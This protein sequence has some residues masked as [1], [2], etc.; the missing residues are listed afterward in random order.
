MFITI[1]LK[2]LSIFLIVAIGIAAS[3]F[4]LVPGD[5]LGTL[6]SFVLNIA[7]PCMVL[8]S[9]QRDEI[10][11]Y[12]TN[13]I[14]WS[15]A[16][17]AIV[18]L[19]VLLLSSL[20]I[21]PVKA[22]KE[23]D[24]GIYRLQLA[25]TNCGFMGY[26]LVTVILGKYALFLAIIMNIV[27]TTL[28]YSV[29]I[30]TLEHQRG[31]KIVIMKIIGQMLTL[32]FISSIAG[33]IIFATGYHF[34]AFINDSL[35][36]MAATLSPMAMFVVGVNLSRARLKDIFTLRNL[37]LCILSLVVV[38]ALTLAV[39]LILPVSK[40]VLTTHVFLMA[41]PSPAVV[42]ILCHRYRKNALL[43]SEGVAATTFLSLGT[44]SLW[45]FLLT[46]VFL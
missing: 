29:G 33:I 40:A 22:V 1:L 43:A 8:Q 45:A 31:E 7:V 38:P 10:K 9:M 18:T 12:M 34:P 30:F 17:F 42:T 41:M 4:K 24:K 25:F 16:A 26:P 2:I 3:K 19:L 13:D 5:C 14:I 35:E 39:D 37:V 20:I 11:G 36:L 15:L 6:N 32:P 21:K 44:L 27:F 28:L 46:N 23:A